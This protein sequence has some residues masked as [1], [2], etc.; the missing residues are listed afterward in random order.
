M[1]LPFFFSI[2]GMK[3]K[4]AGATVRADKC[5]FVFSKST[6]AAS[7]NIDRYQA[8]RSLKSYCLIL[9]AI[10]I[11]MGS[12]QNTNIAY[13]FVVTSLHGEQIFILLFLLL[14]SCTPSLLLVDS[15]RVTACLACKMC[16]Y[17]WARIADLRKMFNQSS[18]NSTV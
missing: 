11:R 7:S 15:V 6:A 9:F 10:S 13:S 4:R 12:V 8:T 14:L 1:R 3:R 2:L 16:I 18:P 5:S 17:L